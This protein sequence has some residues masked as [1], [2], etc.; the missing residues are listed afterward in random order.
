M[1]TL[2]PV[3]ETSPRRLGM[4]PSQAEFAA[5][6]LF[7]AQV[8]IVGTLAAITVTAKSQSDPAP[9]QVTTVTPTWNVDPDGGV[10]VTVPQGPDVVGGE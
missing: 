10:H 3:A 4:T 2:H 9:V 8:V 6:V 7:V 1:V 5:T